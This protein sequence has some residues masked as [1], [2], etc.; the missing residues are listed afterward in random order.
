[1]N[2]SCVSLLRAKPCRARVSNFT[3]REKTFY[4]LH[5]DIYIYLLSDW[6]QILP[7][8]YYLNITRGTRGLVP[9]KKKKTLTSRN[10]A[11]NEL[12]SSCYRG[13]EAL[14]N[15][16]LRPIGFIKSVIGDSEIVYDLASYKCT[17]QVPE[18]WIIKLLS[19]GKKFSDEYKSSTAAST[20]GVCIYDWY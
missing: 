17:T 15:N 6:S 7:K 20:S 14:K 19:G 18:K 3:T 13:N 9:D 12:K 5:E 2:S 1:M 16:E 10:A 11:I 4:T 8:I